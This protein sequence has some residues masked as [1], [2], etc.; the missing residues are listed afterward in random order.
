M[1][2]WVMKNNITLRL[3]AF[4]LGAVALIFGRYLLGRIPALKEP[5]SLYRQVLLFLFAMS[6]SALLYLALDALAH[7]DLTRALSGASHVT[8][9]S[10]EV[11]LVAAGSVSLF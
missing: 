9:N 8:L 7:G 1:S 10:C 5:R 11:S 3:V 4:G 2:E 6:I